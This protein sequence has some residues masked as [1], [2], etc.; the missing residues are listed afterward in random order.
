MGGLPLA[1][2]QQA[3]LPT[4]GLSPVSPTS[5][6]S[7]ELLALLKD[8]TSP[9]QS[10]SS[11]PRHSDMRS[12]PSQAFG[13]ESIPSRQGRAP[14]P[15]IS[16]LNEQMVRQQRLMQLQQLQAQAQQHGLSAQ[17]QQQLQQLMQRL[18][19]Q[20]MTPQQR[21]ALNQ[22]LMQQQSQLGQQPQ[23]QRQAQLLQTAQSQQPQQAQQP[24]QQQQ[25]QQPQPQQQPV[26]GS[27]DGR[28]SV[29]VTD[30]SVS[31]HPSSPL[32]NNHLKFDSPP[33]DWLM[34]GPA[35]RSDSTTSALDTEKPQAPPSKR[36]SFVDT[37]VDIASV[38]SARQNGP[39]EVK[40]ILKTSSSFRPRD[41]TQ[42]DRAEQAQQQPPQ[43]QQQP[44]QQRQLRPSRSQ[45]M[46]W[47]D[48]N[49]ASAPKR[50]VGIAPPPRSIQKFGSMK[51]LLA[52]A[53]AQQVA[54]RRN[55]KQLSTA[56]AAASAKP[57]GPEVSEAK[58]RA[59]AEVA[60]TKMVNP[61]AP[62][63]MHQ[64]LFESHSGLEAIQPKEKNKSKGNPHRSN[65]HR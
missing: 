57:A 4:P 1:S 40:G 20:S 52:D 2:L 7:E 48:G 64:S 43:Q 36:T 5:Q 18:Q 41:E 49:A 21:Q 61:L 35:S 3:L 53:A 11:S 10:E 38:R 19:L 12:S 51:D 32:N 34:G 25:A 29:S 23:S 50:P 17:Q 37:P 63:A 22:Q 27:D 28:S 9:S 13:T 42:P 60:R 30:P 44:Q 65:P 6:A 33:S 15:G 8:M 31:P 62:K 46:L 14:T 59:E 16:G 45:Q 58:L 56:R 55:A 26:A 47:P 54:S 24:A 39:K